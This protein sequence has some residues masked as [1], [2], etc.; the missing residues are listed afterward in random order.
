MSE[1]PLFIRPFQTEDE[2]AVV[3]LWQLCELTVPWNNPYKDIARKLKVTSGIRLPIFSCDAVFILT[4]HF[5]VSKISFE[6]GTEI[7]EM[8]TGTLTQFWPNN[9]G[10]LA[11]T[12][13]TKNLS[14]GSISAA[15]AKLSGRWSEEAG[16]QVDS[17]IGDMLVGYN[18]GNT[19]FDTYSMELNPDFGLAKS[20]EVAPDG[21][22]ITFDLREA[23]YHNIAPVN[24]RALVAQDVALAYARM[25]AGRQVGML[26]GLNKVEAVDDR[27]VKFNMDIPN[28]DIIIDKRIKAIKTFGFT[29]SRNV[30]GN[31]GA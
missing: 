19:D 6:I 5:Y 3:S 1:R 14:G 13:V 18:H 21:L 15:R 30:F 27:T 11:R 24:G 31:A 28:A 12:W 4:F 29:T 2:T 25:Q 10:P 7:K 22:S 16:P 23:N 20:W 9:L 17:L 8:K 26:K